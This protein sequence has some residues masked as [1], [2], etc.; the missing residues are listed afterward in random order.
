MAVWMLPVEP[1]RYFIMM[2]VARAAI[3]G[4]VISI[5]AG[6]GRRGV[7]DSRA[8]R[9]SDGRID[10]ERQ[11]GADA[12]APRRV[13]DVRHAVVSF[14]LG[15]LD[16]VSCFIGPERVASFTRSSVISAFMTPELQ[17]LE[18]FARFEDDDDSQHT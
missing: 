7:T 14:L 16:G 9:S 8:P 4:S 15:P 2:S 12:A 5:G 1:W 17:N 13:T 10:H 6:P 11:G 3:T 18:K